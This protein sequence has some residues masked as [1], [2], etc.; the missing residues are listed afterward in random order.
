MRLKQKR[1]KA[2]EKTGRSALS[3]SFAKEGRRG[4]LGDAAKAPN[5]NDLGFCGRMYDRRPDRSF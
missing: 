1:L 4:F 5:L 2:E 3:P